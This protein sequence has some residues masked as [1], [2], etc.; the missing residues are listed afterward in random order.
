MKFVNGW[1]IPDGDD[2][3][4]HPVSLEHDQK[5]FDIIDQHTTN[6]N[7]AVD[8]GGNVGKWACQLAKSFAQVSVFEPAPYHIECFEINCKN[9][10]NIKLHKYGLSNKP[11]LGN[12]DISVPG[13]Y[14][15]TRILEDDQ[16]SIEMKTLDSLV[17]Q[18]IDVIK[19]DVEGRELHVLQG[20]KHTLQKFSPLVV[21]ERCEMNSKAFGYNKKATHDLLTEYGYKLIYKLTRDCVYKK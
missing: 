15:S 3:L 17:F 12:L 10:S 2:E 4:H 16:G 5:L 9:H 13:H 11:G 1:W 20:S 6:F 14:G 21:I 8:V 18:D 19:I 7:H